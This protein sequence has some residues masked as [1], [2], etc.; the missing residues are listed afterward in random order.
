MSAEQITTFRT[1]SIHDSA[2]ICLMSADVEEKIFLTR[3]LNELF[4]ISNLIIE[5]DQPAHIIPV[6][7]RPVHPRLVSPRDLSKR[8]MR[9]EKGRAALVHSIAHIEFNA[10]NLALDVVYRFR[11][12][13]RTFY[14]D[15]LQVAQ[16]EAYHFGLLENHLNKLGYAYGDF[17]GHNGLW[18]MAVE[19]D[20]D[21]LVRMALVPRVMEARGLDVT[22]GIIAKFKQVG[23]QDMMEILSIIQQDE[24]GH[25]ETGTRW[26]RY[27]CEQRAW[28]PLET[29]K[30]LIEKHMSGGVRGPY[31]YLRRKQAGFT[32]DE[33][34]YLE[35]AGA[36]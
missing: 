24:V 23:D 11:G 2:C 29:F 22:P 15:W 36:R 7:G 8:S 18:E 4:Q 28:P 3:T 21:V 33:L 19:T 6:P 25:V 17:N 10:I 5:S 9:D 20:Y 27:F 32:D 16:E 12:Q 30:K 13:P 34:E 31:D 35:Q 1:Q 14:A 26:Y